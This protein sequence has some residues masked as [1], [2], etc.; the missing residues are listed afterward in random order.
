MDSSPVL[1]RCWNWLFSELR[2]ESTG[3]L[4]E[5]ASAPFTILLELFLHGLDAG[6]DVLVTIGDDRLARPTERR[7]QRWINA[8]AVGCVSRWRFAAGVQLRPGR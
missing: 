3:A 2:V 8:A 6:F 4:E 5:T 7:C 1:D